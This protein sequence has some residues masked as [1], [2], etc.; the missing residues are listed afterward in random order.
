VK[1]E[2]LWK[3][4]VVKQYETNKL[5]YLP[6]S[7]QSMKKIFAI[8]WSTRYNSSNLNILKVIQ[9]TTRE[10][11]EITI[12]DGFSGIPHFN[13]D[14]DRENPPKEVIELRDMIH[15]ADGVLICTPEYIFSL[16]GSLKNLLEWCVS[17]TLF[18]DKPVALI[19]ASAS[20]E[21]WHE[22]LLLIMKTLGA[23][24]N[25]GTTLLISGVKG[26]MNTNG[27]II[28]TTTQDQIQKLVDSFVE[29][30]Q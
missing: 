30:I 1:N 5:G 19:T 4:F 15:Q 24:Y 2:N 18:T 6:V 26:K 7:I 9:S 23:R 8:S 25:D 11:F 22:E 16:P 14:I 17:T 29:Q 3:I 13:P 27:E 28:D 20:G 12:Y 21:K 10:L